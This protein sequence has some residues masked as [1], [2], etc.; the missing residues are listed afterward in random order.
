MTFGFLPASSL[1][2]DYYSPTDD[3]TALVGRRTKRHYRLNDR[4]SVVVAK[5]DRVKRMID[6]EA[7]E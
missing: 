5:V 7:V 2:S 3:G 6:F 1:P 4:L